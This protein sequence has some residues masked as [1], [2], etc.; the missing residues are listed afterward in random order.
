[1]YPTPPLSD[2][3]VDQLNEHTSVTAR[4]NAWLDR[5]RPFRDSNFRKRARSQ[6]P[7]HLQYFPVESLLGRRQ[8]R[9][10]N[11]LGNM[12]DPQVSR[13]ILIFPKRILTAQT[14][15]ISPTI[16]PKKQQYETSLDSIRINV[17]T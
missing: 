17:L 14:A 2:V 3:L 5:S 9:Y 1:M 8:A 4:V 11:S 7:E 13:A 12:S 10:R 16:H 6:S 15:N